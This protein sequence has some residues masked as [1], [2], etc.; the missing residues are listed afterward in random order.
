MLIGGVDLDIV[1]SF[2]VVGVKVFGV[3]GVFVLLWNIDVG[4]FEV[5]VNVVW[6][7]VVIVE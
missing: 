1:N 5:I 4:N 7:F 3:G 6:F 2:L